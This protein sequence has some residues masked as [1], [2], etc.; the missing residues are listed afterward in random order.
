MAATFSATFPKT[1][2]VWTL[3]RINARRESSR[4]FDMLTDLAF[5]KEQVLQHDKRGLN[6]FWTTNQL[7]SPLRRI[8]RH[9]AH[10]DQYIER[11][12]LVP[13]NSRT[14]EGRSGSGSD[15]DEPY[16]PVEMNQ[17]GVWDA[18]TFAAIVEP[19]A[20]RS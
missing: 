2:A 12:V 7:G 5:Q 17:V 15:F 9:I 19:R 4:R 16:L 13:G 18:I 10:H 8:L 11:T 6:G 14:E 1:T 3:A 20:H